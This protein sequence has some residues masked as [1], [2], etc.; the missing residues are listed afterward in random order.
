MVL[1]GGVDYPQPEIKTC[2]SCASFGLRLDAKGRCLPPPWPGVHLC[3][4]PS[5][6]FTPETAKANPPVS[7]VV[8]VGLHSTMLEMGPGTW[9]HSATS[10]TGWRVAVVRGARKT[11]SRRKCSQPG[12]VTVQ[13][14]GAA[15]AQGQMAAVRSRRA[16]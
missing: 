7:A 14:V 15:R 1:L 13:F 8:A 11:V 4:A 6:T 2:C 9:L 10:I 12:S 3:M 16:L 5:C